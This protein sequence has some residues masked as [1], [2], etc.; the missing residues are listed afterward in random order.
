MEEMDFSASTPPHPTATTFLKDKLTIKFISFSKNFVHQ[1]ALK[2][3]F[4]YS[5]GACA[6]TMDGDFQHPP[7]LIPQMLT[8]WKTVTT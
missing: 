2:A 8:L 4:D 3:G 1:V 5:T 6:I 7:A